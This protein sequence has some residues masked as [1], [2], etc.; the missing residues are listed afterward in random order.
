[1][2]A[3]VG[4][5]PVRPLRLARGRGRPRLRAGDADAR[6]DRHVVVRRL[7]AGRVGPD[8][9]ARDVA[10][11]V[12]RQ[13]RADDVERPVA[14]R[15]PR[16]LVRVPLRRGEG[17]PRGRHRGL[18][19]RQRLRRLRRADEGRLRARRPVARTTTGPVALPTQRRDTLFDLQRYHGGAL[20][21]YALRQDVGAPTFQRIE[22]AWVAALRGPV[23]VAPTTSSRSPSQ[24]SGRNLDGRSC[25]TGSTAPRRRRCRATRTGRSTRSWR[26]PRRPCPPPRRGRRS[27]GASS[28][29]SAPAPSRAPARNVR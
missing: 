28:R 27:S 20:V 19:G 14:Q 10:H 13:R 3:R 29:L 22:R 15:G 4:T 21:L 16:Q 12:R 9:A 25:A 24:V 1:M 26:T 18:P 8:A 17:L 7:H 23:G 11:V 6:A 5:L 2:Q